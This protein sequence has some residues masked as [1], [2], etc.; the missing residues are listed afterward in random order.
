MGC[1]A[2]LVGFD[3]GVTMR[4]VARGRVRRYRLLAAVFLAAAMLF[5]IVATAE[6]G[7]ITYWRSIQPVGTVGTNIPVTIQ[8]SG[9][10]DLYP[11]VS[12]SAKLYVD[13]V[14]KPRSSYTASILRTSVY[15]RYVPT[16]V[17]SDG[18]H[19]FRVEVSDTSG[20]LSFYQWIATVRQPP[21]ASWVAPAAGAVSY[22]GRPVITMTLAD[23]TPATTFSVSGQV[24]T[25]SAA[26][27]V[28]ATFSG[29]GLS[30]GQNTFQT[31]SALGTGTYYLTASVTDAGGNT[32]SLQGYAARSFVVEGAEPMSVLSSC[33]GCHDSYQSAH[34]TPVTTDCGVCHPNNVDDHMEGTEYCEDCHWDG[35]HTGGAGVSVAVTSPCTDCHRLSRP[36]VVQHAAATVGP[37]HEGSCDGCHSESLLAQHAITPEGSSFAYQCDLCHGP[38]ASQQVKDAIA[39]GDTACSACHDNDHAA[40][41]Q[42]TVPANCAGCHDG[43]SLIGIHAEPGCDGCH[44]S[45]DAGVIAAIAAGNTDCASCHGGGDHESLHQV[46]VPANCAGCHAGTSLTGIHEESSCAGC[47]DSTDADVIAA[48]TAEDKDCASCHSLQEHPNLDDSTHTGTMTSG[49]MNVFDYHEGYS[50]LIW[51]IPCSM[52]HGTTE[53]LPIH[54]NNCAACHSGSK[55]ADSF[56]T[57]N[58]SCQQGACH[59]TIV[60]PSADPAHESFDCEAACHEQDWSVEYGSC[61]WC[62]EPIQTLAPYTTSN[63]KTAYVGSA[64]ISFSTAGVTTTYYQLDGGSPVAAKSLVVPGPSTGTATHTIEYWSVSSAGLEQVPHRNATFTVSKDTNAP[65]TTSNAV[66][67]YIGPA[68]ITLSVTDDNSS[69][70]QA[71]YYRLNGGTQTSGKTISI[72]QPASGT[73]SYTLEF[74]SVDAAGNTELPHKSASFTITA[75]KLAPITTSNAPAYDRTTTSLRVDFIATDPAPATGVANTYYRVNNG[76][77]YPRNWVYL[78]G[79]GTYELR[80]WSTDKVGNREADNYQTVIK[81]WTAPTTTTNALPSYTGTATIHLTPTD[82]LAGVATTYYILDAEPQASGTDVTATINGTH[83]IKYWSVDKAGNIETQKTVTFTVTG[84]APDTAPPV[85]TSNALPAYTGNATIVLSPGDGSGSGVAATYYRL[86]GGT[87]KTGTTVAVPQPPSGTVGHTLVFWSVDNA[88]NIE[89]E[90]SVSFTVT[91]AGTATLAFVWHPWD[92]AEAHLRV[93]NA[94]GV[95]IVDTWVDGYDTDLD[96]YVTVPAGQNYYMECIFYYDDETG[97]DGGPYG[98][99]SNDRVDGWGN[100]LNADG[101]LSP[102]ETV[103]WYY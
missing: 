14:L 12:T 60:H 98:V 83:T 58:D 57:W 29:T 102:G 44:D 87:Q 30:A 47:H 75:D 28:V 63:L 24:R 66:T 56:P 86:D 49:P 69:P 76:A 90:K 37:D 91:Q 48:I 89:S 38:S 77:T 16:P 7:P 11:L 68:T 103:I 43:T 10:F 78:S 15:F 55:P 19:T 17:L 20:R 31:S 94:S 79:Q 45:T 36:E 101:I 84:A 53:L 41:H 22:D 27:P 72:P 93:E 97:D 100:P 81:D 96:L 2:R 73:L 95:P 59:P 18:A 1:P 74:W 8:G 26:G 23:N 51:D 67:A 70:V 92:W 13:D 54:G 82:T 40:A 50:P 6:A 34:T 25:G 5:G 3:T 80:F 33:G 85:T 46:T 99:W 62:H 9:P 52:C 64:P 61:D 88:G 35:W 42:V 71:T 4:Q 21:S 32:M 39:S 65:T